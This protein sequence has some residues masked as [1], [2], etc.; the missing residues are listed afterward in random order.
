MS[1][2]ELAPVTIPRGRHHHLV[3][4]VVL[5]RIVQADRRGSPGIAIPDDRRRQTGASQRVDL[6]HAHVV[7]DLATGPTSHS[8]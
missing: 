7:D 4:L 2:P 8:Q 6:F 3:P 5:V 1:L